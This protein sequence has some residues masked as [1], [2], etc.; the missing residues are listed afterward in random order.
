MGY[1]GAPA[2]QRLLPPHESTEG[3][4]VACLTV[5]WSPG[6]GCRAPERRSSSA[7]VS[8]YNPLIGRFTRLG[9]LLNRVAGRWGTLIGLAGQGVDGVRRMTICTGLPSR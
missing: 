6:S 9:S 7:L 2:S 1:T 4:A 5:L 8:P 3:H